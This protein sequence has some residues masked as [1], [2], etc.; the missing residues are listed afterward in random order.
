MDSIIL[1]WMVPPHGSLIYPP[2]EKKTSI[3]LLRLGFK[4]LRCRKWEGKCRSTAENRFSLQEIL[5]QKNNRG[6]WGDV[7]FFLVGVI[8]TL[9]TLHWKLEPLFFRVSQSFSAGFVCHSTHQRPFQ[10]PGGMRW[11]W[12]ML[13][14]WLG[15]VQKCSVFFV[16]F[17]MMMDAV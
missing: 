13:L 10:Q 15:W 16:F 11:G 9:S 12:G 14:I 4:E 1:L 2:V 6:I 8:H 5:V 17:R 7:C 3:R